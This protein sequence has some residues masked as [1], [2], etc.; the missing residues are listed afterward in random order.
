MRR[1]L[2]FS[3]SHLYKYFN[4]APCRIRLS[5]EFKTCLFW[6]QNGNTCKKLS[7]ALH[8]SLCHYSDSGLNTMQRSQVYSTTFEIPAVPELDCLH[9]DSHT[10]THTHTEWRLVFHSAK[11]ILKRVKPS[12][13][14]YKP[15]T[16]SSGSS[17][18]TTFFKYL[19]CDKTW[20]I[21]R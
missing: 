21:W 15:Q 1:N 13:T 3:N 11:H 6:W 12:Q 14:D 18:R 16:E 5:K 9:R 17:Y 10:R 8:A 19:A 2:P 4:P 7:V 20:V